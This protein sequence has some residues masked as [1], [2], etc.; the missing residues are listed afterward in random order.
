[1][2]LPVAVMFLLGIV[3][4]FAGMLTGVRQARWYGS[5]GFGMGLAIFA[6][7]GVFLSHEFWQALLVLVATGGILAL[8]VW[9]GFQSGGYYRNQPMP[10]KL[11]LMAACVAAAIILV[12]VAA[13]ILIQ[14]L[15]LESR[16]FFC[17]SQ[18]KM[19][20]NGVVCKVTGFPGDV[21][22]VD[23]NGKTILDEKTG[24]RMK[25]R[26]FP[27]HTA[28]DWPTFAFFGTLDE[29]RGRYTYLW[30]LRRFYDLLGTADKTLW[31]WTHDGRIVGYDSV[32]RRQTGALETP[33]NPIGASRATAG[34]M[35]PSGNSGHEPI[36]ASSTTVYRVNL[37]NRALKAIFSVT[38]DDKIGGYNETRVETDDNNIT[39][40]GVIVVTGKS[41]HFL[42]LDGRVQW[43]VPYQPSYPVYP[44]VNVYLLEPT[45]RFAVEFEPDRQAD[46]KSGWKLPTRIEWVT[47]GESITKSMDLPKLPQPKRIDFREILLLRLMPPPLQTAVALWVDS[48][49]IWDS[50]CLMPAVLCAMI[51]WGLGRRHDF[52][53]RAQAGWVVF[54]LFFG[55]PGL[56]AFLS[57]QEWPARETCPN[58][59]K[60]R[61]VDREKCPHCGAAFAPPEKNGTEIFAPLAAD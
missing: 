40:R 30:D 39:S 17:Y 32:T 31:Y 1:M 53:A 6:T 41:I 14:S 2:T 5:R 44:R 27:L 18:Y 16:D 34:F 24:R 50:P 23:L 11:A 54:H 43:S 8:A 58:C 42:D 35:H 51:G 29:W 46:K 60:L 22:I 28:Q 38:N 33:G 52:P 4:Y 37:E 48:D 19:T 12:F 9:G 61:V 3:Y 56:L 10:G 45:N 25:I 55:L 20:T 26:N 15:A 57:V 36:L 47:A 7:M 13:S 49:V 59:K 21:E